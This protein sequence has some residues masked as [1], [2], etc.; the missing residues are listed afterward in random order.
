MNN[1]EEMDD[2]V[3]VPSTSSQAMQREL[4][5]YGLYRGVLINKQPCFK[6]FAKLDG[7]TRK[8]IDEDIRPRS[9]RN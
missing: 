8:E 6:A 5:G 7:P 1:N 9:E 2:M 4:S 3:N